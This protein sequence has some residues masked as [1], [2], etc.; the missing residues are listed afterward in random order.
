[1]QAKELIC[2]DRC[3]IM[4]FDN[5]ARQLLSYSFEG[6]KKANPAPLLICRGT[7]PTINPT[8]HH[9]S[10]TAIHAQRLARSQLH[11]DAG[12]C[13]VVCA[14]R[15]VEAGRA[16]LFYRRAV[17][18]VKQGAA[19][20]SELPSRVQLPPSFAFSACSAASCAHSDWFLL[21]LCGLA[22]FSILA[23]FC[24][25]CLSNSHARR[26]VVRCGHQESLG[27]RGAGQSRSRSVLAEP[28]V[29]IAGSCALSRRG[30]NVRDAKSDRQVHAAARD[31]FES[32]PQSAWSRPATRLVQTVPCSK[33]RTAPAFSF[34]SHQ[35]K[36]LRPALN[37]KSFPG[38]RGPIDLD[39]I[40][41]IHSMGTLTYAPRVQRRVPTHILTTCSAEIKCWAPQPQLSPQCV[42]RRL[43]RVTLRTFVSLNVD[44]NERY[45][46]ATK[47]TMW[48]CAMRMLLA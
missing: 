4:L 46:S 37:A 31:Q 3:T 2:A 11:P 34:C 40:W 22:S 23:A 26:Y 1:M 35:R 43:H 33:Q 19:R 28:Q 16:R 18:Q 36:C 9:F 7:L 45:T 5:D 42:S 25:F 12:A 14:S 32:D 24:N 44:A 13:A 17:D 38:D 41:T 30:V 6:V 15:N 20:V 8:A 21:L 48:Q 27:K 47:S 10:G 39:L 29:G